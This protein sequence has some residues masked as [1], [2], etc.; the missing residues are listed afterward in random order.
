[1]QNEIPDVS[2]NLFTSTKWIND[3]PFKLT[4]SP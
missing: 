1:M 3:E 4:R 2:F